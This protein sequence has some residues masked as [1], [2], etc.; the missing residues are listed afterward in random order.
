MDDFTDRFSRRTFIYFIASKDA[1]IEIL[2]VFLTEIRAKNG[3]MDVRIIRSDNGGEFTGEAFKRALLNENIWHELTQPY[4]P[5]QNGIGAHEWKILVMVRCMLRSADAPKFLWA[6]AA[7]YAVHI[8]N[9]LPHRSNPDCI[10]PYERWNDIKPKLDSLFVWGSPAYVLIPKQR[11]KDSK[12]GDVSITGMIVGV[13]RNREAFRIYIPSQHCIFESS[14]IEI[15]EHELVTRAQA[16]RRITAESEGEPDSLV[17]DD[18]E[19]K[20]T[21]ISTDPTTVIDRAVEPPTSPPS[22]AV[23]PSKPTRMPPATPITPATVPHVF[24]PNT[25]P[26]TTPPRES[27]FRIPTPKTSTRTVPQAASPSSVDAATAAPPSPTTAPAWSGVEENECM[28][29]EAPTSVQ[30]PRRVSTRFTKGM[31]PANLGDNYANERENVWRKKRGMQVMQLIREGVNYVNALKKDLPTLEEGLRSAD[32]EMWKDAMEIELSNLIKRGTW[33]P[34]VLPSGRKLVGHK[35]VLRIKREDDGSIKK[36]KARL[37]VKGYSQVFGI[38]F[39]ETF[40]PTI[41]ADSWRT[42]YACAAELGSSATLFQWD[43]VGAYLWADL[44]EEI[45]MECPVGFKLPKGMNCVRLLKALYGLKQAGR[46]WHQLLK[47]VLIDMEFKPAEEDTCLF[48]HECNGKTT[49]LGVHV[50]DLFGWTT[51]PEFL[52]MVKTRLDTEFELVD[53]GKVKYLLGIHLERNGITG[54]IKLHQEKYIRDVLERFGMSDCHP[55]RSPADPSVHLEAEDDSTLLEENV[56]YREAVGALL[57][58]AV[59]T[60]PCIAYA[61]S[62]VAKFVENPR[63]THWTAVKRIMRFLKGNP[64]RGISYQRTTGEPKLSVFCDADYAEDVDSRKSTT[65]YVA[66]IAGGP[67]A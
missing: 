17:A 60:V 59:N 67:V 27:L 46:L 58:A 6:E 55:V 35:W 52:R 56:P 10:S 22:V 2:S 62:K 36:F 3:N 42:M 7:E 28:E 15:D 65:E 18:E 61:V 63:Q 53:N 45:Y 49:M 31:K 51:E 66:F 9:S 19:E 40:A 34:A 39:D 11:R 12:L 37:T 25:M 43:I 14:D 1:A 29:D 23:T 8:L 54:A 30:L 4:S 13:A 47:K 21:H 32:S 16:A 26:P 64:K 48:V 41:R 50:D 20:P 5:E 44:D 38:D 33:E 57:Y 24:T